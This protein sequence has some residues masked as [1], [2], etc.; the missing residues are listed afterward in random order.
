[1]RFRK[2]VATLPGK[3]DIVFREKRVAVFCDGDFWHGRNWV[4]RRRKLLNG[5]NH[6][7][8]I[9]KIQTNI[10]RDKRHN[11]ELRKLGWKVVRLWE[12]DILTDVDAAVNSV[13]R[14]LDE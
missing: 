1:L 12:T 4:Q 9:I 10:D 5:A 8:W 11:R 3:P 7:Y 2:N 14:A 6:S 13:V